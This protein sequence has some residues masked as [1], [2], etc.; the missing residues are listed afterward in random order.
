MYSD[1]PRRWSLE[2]Y[3]E[4]V[5][6][7]AFRVKV[8]VYRGTPVTRKRTPLGPYRRPMPRVLE[9]SYGGGCFLMGVWGRL[10]ESHAE[11]EDHVAH[12]DP[13]FV[14]TYI[15]IYIYIYT[16]TYIYTHIYIY[17]YVYAYIHI[18]IL[19]HTYIY[20]YMYTYTYMYIYVYIYIYL[21]IY[22]YIY[23]SIYIYIYIYI[24]F[25][26]WGLGVWV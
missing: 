26:V 8:E 7:V 3:S 23:L 6:H 24:W 1:Q 13:A 14:A 4:A 2:I 9:G 21:Y 19:T 5:D 22:I 10:L 18:Y 12:R 25:R 17:I 11:A 20:I 15:Y 16:Y